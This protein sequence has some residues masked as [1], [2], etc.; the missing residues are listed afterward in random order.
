MSRLDLNSNIGA[1]LRARQRGFLLWPGRFSQEETSISYLIDSL[2]ASPKMAYGMR[3]LRSTYDGYCIKVTRSSDSTTQDIGFDASGNLDTASLLSFVGTGTGY[4]TIWYD[5]SGNS[6]NLTASANAPIVSAGTLVT[7]G[8]AGRAS[9]N[10]YTS[11]PYFTPASTPAASNT[12]EVYSVIALN[13]TATGSYHTVI[14]G[15]SGALEVRLSTTLYP[16]AA[17]QGG[18]AKVTHTTAVTDTSPHRFQ[19]YGTSS[20]WSVG[21]DGSFTT[22]TGAISI[23]GGVSRVLGSSSGNKLLGYCSEILIF[24][25]ALTAADRTLIDTSQSTYYS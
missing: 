16:T 25:T 4:V 14:G 12:N 9:I 7:K 23:T 17:F 20:S 22:I 5:Q 3:K 10:C 15:G 19:F 13:S 21:L 18:S 6:N 1:A 8:T 24:S 11:S 2:S